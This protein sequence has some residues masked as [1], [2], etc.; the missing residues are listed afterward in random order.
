MHSRLSK[1]PVTYA[2]AQVKFSNIENIESRI[3]ELQEKIRS[4]FPHF[5]KLDIQTIQLKEGQQLNASVWTQWHFIDKEKQTGIILDKQ[6]L[7]IHT[8]HYE[9]F[10]PLLESF[11]KVATRFHEI[12][13]F[14]LS[15]KI[16]LRY[17]NIIENGLTE[18][19]SGLQ[20][21]LLKGDGFNKKHF[22]TRTETTQPTN[23]GFIKVQ[24]T[25]ITDKQAIANI[26]NV[27][28][29]PDLADI[30]KLLSFN[31]HKEPKHEFLVLDLDH[32]N[33]S[34]S[35][36]DVKQILQYFNQIQELLY[37]AFCQAIGQANLD[38]WR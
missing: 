31:H 20:G 15:T 10:Q 38:N 8:S 28:V 17:I 5:Q 21:F 27:F 33:N 23:A 9:Q 37:Q 26:K 25:R 2:L 19:N 34:Q 1:P 4:F 13:N 6:S 29:P 30:A 32:F 3:P 7:T 18:I 12:L 35:D 24:A 22:F 36:F 16:G 14:S 11:E